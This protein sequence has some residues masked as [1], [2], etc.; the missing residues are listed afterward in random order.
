MC[1]NS[2]PLYVSCT[3]PI[4]ILIKGVCV[5]HHLCLTSLLTAA[6]AENDMDPMVSSFDLKWHVSTSTFLDV[7]SG[8]DTCSITFVRL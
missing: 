3:G 7:V 2:L 5:P 4:R 1:D 8:S 6:I